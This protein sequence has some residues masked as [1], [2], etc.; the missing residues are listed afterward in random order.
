ML[1]STCH[2]TNAKYSKCQRC[3]SH[4][5]PWQ[6]LQADPNQSLRFDSSKSIWSAS[7]PAQLFWF[8]YL[9]ISNSEQLRSWRVSV[10]PEVTAVFPKH[11]SVPSDCTLSGYDAG[12]VSGAETRSGVRLVGGSG[13]VYANASWQRRLFPSAARAQ[14]HTYARTRTRTHEPLQSFGLHLLT[15]HSRSKTLCRRRQK[16]VV[17]LSETLPS[18]LLS[19][20]RCSPP[21]CRAPLLKTLAS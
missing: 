21:D 18:L 19:T 3:G 9:F 8:I 7:S 16:E 17:R 20:S 10:R 13:R 11:V 4:L 14:T 15:G 1:T 5:S 6:L 2:Q 12:L